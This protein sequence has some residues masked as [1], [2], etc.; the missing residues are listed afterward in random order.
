M[1]RISQNQFQQHQKIGAE[2]EV[3][4]LYNDCDDTYPLTAEVEN[5]TEDDDIIM[6]RKIPTPI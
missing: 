1:K 3:A 5:Y 6:K 2:F 4:E